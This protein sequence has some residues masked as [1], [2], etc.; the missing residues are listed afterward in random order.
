MPTKH[1]H[2]RKSPKGIASK[3]PFDGTDTVLAEDFH[4][5]EFH[6]HAVALMPDPADKRPGVAVRVEAAGGYV[7]Q[8]SC[9][10]RI[11]TVATCVHLKELHRLARAFQEK[12]GNRKVYEDFAASTWYHL[13]GILAG[14]SRE[15]PKTV[16]LMTVRHDD[17][18]AVTVAGRSGDRL[19]TYISSGLDHARFLERCTLPPEDTAVPTR[20]AVIQSL[21]LLTLSENERLL[22]DRGL[23]TRRQALEESFWYKIA[24]HGYREF[25]IDGCTLHPA[26]EESTGAFVLKGNTAPDKAVFVIEIPRKKV[27]RVLS[28]CGRMLSN[29]HGLVV[30][31][32]PLDSIFDVKLN[33]NLDVE[34]RSLMR[35]IQKNGEARFFERQDLKRFQYGDLYYIKELGILAEDRYP[36]PPPATFGEPVKT[37]IKRS[38]VPNFLEKFETDLNIV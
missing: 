15:T 1:K 22:L 21:S 33:R 31:P 29:H 20:G 4:R 8:Q 19:L 14:E 27:K 13:A 9:S 36:E 12:L 26:I 18:E 38:Q 6:R 32:I 3:I 5:L 23:K 16:R 28:E 24:Y 37:V 34:I 10:C 2:K 35:L 25:G 17:Q 11:S 30:H 7:E